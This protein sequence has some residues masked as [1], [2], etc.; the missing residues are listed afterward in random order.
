M[1]LKFLGCFFLKEKETIK[2]VLGMTEPEG[3]KIG[4]PEG[5][6]GEASV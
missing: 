3:E 6:M 2:Q 4:N 1:D 5:G